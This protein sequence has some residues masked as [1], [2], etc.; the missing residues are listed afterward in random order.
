[1]QTLGRR[2]EALISYRNAI[3]F[4][5]TMSMAY[6]NSAIVLVELDRGEDAEKV[7]LQTKN[8]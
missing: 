4:R 5:P 8:V 3:H 2:Q 7:Y 1:M 6:L